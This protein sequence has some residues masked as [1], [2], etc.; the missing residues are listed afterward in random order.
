MHQDLIERIRTLSS[1]LVPRPTG[2]EPCLEALP[3]LRAVLFDIYGTLV[4][5]ASG[6]VGLAG[7][8]DETAAFRAALA[9]AG[10]SVPGD[11]GPADLKAAIRAWHSQRKAA[12]VAYPEVD[13]LAVWSSVVGPRA[14]LEE[15]AVEYE[16]R[17]NPVWPMPGLT[18]MLSQIGDRG[19]AL[20]IVSNAQFYTPLML[21]AFLGAPLPELGFDPGCCA[22]SYRLLEAKPS[23][24]IY[25]EALAGLAQRHGIEPGEV[26]YVGNDIRND[27]R[28][29]AEVGC[30]T[31]L[32]A[33]DTRSL[34]LRGDD[35]SCAGVRP[36][37]IVT[38]LR[39]IPA[40][41][42]PGS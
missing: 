1:P 28:P 24:R 18:E 17:V 16:C 25:R 33:G 42:L 7:E 40:R 8:R 29:A 32:F 13:I 4:I 23:T 36:D 41:L 35:S 34:R 3:G 12:G 9:A 21:E 20:G 11:R 31:A 14:R 6:D 2:V 39:Q 27:I 30:R 38:D 15:L 19:L 10:I 37:R 26:L 5:S 22:F